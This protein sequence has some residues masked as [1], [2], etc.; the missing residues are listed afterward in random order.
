MTKQFLCHQRKRPSSNPFKLLLP[1]VSC[2]FS[3]S[4]VSMNYHGVEVTWK[5]LCP[6]EALS[7]GFPKRG[8]AVYSA[9][10]SFTQV[11][12]EGYRKRQ[13][14]ALGMVLL[15]SP[16]PQVSMMLLAMR[17]NL[18]IFCLQTFQA[19]LFCHRKSFFGHK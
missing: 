2:L 11:R 18:F 3:K 19:T 17:T 13:L 16:S 1:L 6:R 7:Q 10:S 9:V 8:A 14:P 4:V 5:L 15:A 12:S